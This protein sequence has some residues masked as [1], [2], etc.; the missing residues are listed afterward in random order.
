MAEEEQAVEEQEEKP[1]EKPEKPKKPAKNDIAELQRRKD[2]EVAEA[3]KEAKA[4]RE[5]LGTLQTD[6]EEQRRY[7]KELRERGELSDDEEARLKR[8]I[9]KESSLEKRESAA[10]TYEKKVAAKFLSVEY[11]MP[12]DDLMEYDDP[13]D[14][15]IAALKWERTHRPDEEEEEQEQPAQAKEEPSGF[16]FG[17]GGTSGKTVADVQP[18]S[19]EFWKLHEQRMKEARRRAV[20][21]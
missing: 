21:R 5:Q 2:R 8:L 14:M 7:V 19:E 12:V 20:R 11:G 18:N 3:Q 6:L 13:R 9:E 15:E 16:D 4:L 10:A 17:G 1:E